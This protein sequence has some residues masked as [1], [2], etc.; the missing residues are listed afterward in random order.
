M[1]SPAPAHPIRRIGALLRLLP[2]HRAVPVLRAAVL[3]AAALRSSRGG[4]VPSAAA[5][6]PVPAGDPP[7]APSGLSV[8]RDRLAALPAAERLRSRIPAAARLLP[9]APSPPEAQPPA[10]AAVPTRRRRSGAPALRCVPHRAPGAPLAAAMVPVTGSSS[11]VVALSDAAG[12]RFPVSLQWFGRDAVTELSGAALTGYVRTLVAPFAD[13][14]DL[15]CPYPVGDASALG[16]AASDLGYEK[17]STPFAVHLVER[18]RSSHELRD[19]VAPGVPADASLLLVVP[20]GTGW[21]VLAFDDGVIQP[22]TDVMLSDALQVDQLVRRLATFTR[23][24]VAPQQFLPAVRGGGFHATP[25]ALWLDWLDGPSPDAAIKLLY[26][27]RDPAL[28]RMALYACMGV[29]VLALLAAVLAVYL[30][31]D[32]RAEALR[33]LQESRLAAEAERLRQQGRER[34]GQRLDEPLPWSPEEPLRNLPFVSACR[35]AFAQTPYTRP[36]TDAG[37][38]P[39]GLPHYGSYNVEALECDRAD[40]VLVRRALLDSTRGTLGAAYD[41]RLRWADFA[42]SADAPWQEAAAP[43]PDP[44]DPDPVAARLQSAVPGADEPRGAALED[45]ALAL[46]FE[47]P[48]LALEQVA[49]VAAAGKARMFPGRIDVGRVA[50]SQQLFWAIRTF[51]LQLSLWPDDGSPLH[52]LLAAEPSLVIDRIVWSDWVWT[53]HGRLLAVSSAAAERH[54]DLLAAPGA[55]GTGSAEP[56]R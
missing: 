34:V 24:W 37:L 2:V 33:K 46:L 19:R 53:L 56:R 32:Q 7:P 6:P 50:S 1:P 20:V 8:L 44:L 12:R 29:G 38:Q 52:Q 5:D 55:G 47:P 25:E 39:G 49:A 30:A 14:P 42:F 51:E 4:A 27:L 36:G 45:E 26:P 18:W 3:R 40:G 23:V 54:P 11:R 15:Y 16:V 13:P 31:R 35:Q 28:R 9:A 22:G 41:T 21:Y 48:L 43:L 10:V 17:G